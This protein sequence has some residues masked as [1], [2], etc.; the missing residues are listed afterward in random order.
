MRFLVSIYNSRYA[1]TSK[2]IAVEMVMFMLISTV[3]LCIIQWM[4]HFVCM[5]DFLATLYSLQCPLFI[6]FRRYAP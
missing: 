2:S 6:Y 4:F 3:S 5:S 1:L